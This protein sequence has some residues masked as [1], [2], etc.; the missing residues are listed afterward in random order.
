M[1]LI[2]G[3]QTFCIGMIGEYIGRA[4][5]KLNRKPQFVVGNKTWDQKTENEKT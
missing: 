2:G 4:Y 1:M 5:L 3:I